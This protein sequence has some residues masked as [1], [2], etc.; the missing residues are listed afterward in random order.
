LVVHGNGSAATKAA[1]IVTVGYSQNAQVACYPG[2]ENTGFN[3]AQI[4]P[5]LIATC[6]LT[7]RE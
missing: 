5:E 2:V 6:W 7:K 4:R 3:L 1:A